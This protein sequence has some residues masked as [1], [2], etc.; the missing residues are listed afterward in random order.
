MI[1]LCLNLA[2]A[3]TVCISP[4]VPT[5]ASRLYP[6]LG[7]TG[8]PQRFSEAEAFDLSSDASSPAL[9]VQVGERILERIHP[10]NVQAIIDASKVAPVNAQAPKKSAQKA[11]PSPEA[12]IIKIDDLLKVALRIGHIQ[13]AEEVEGSSKLLKLKVDLAESSPRTIFAGIKE[14]YRPEQLRGK[15][16][17]VVANLK[18]RKMRFGT[19]EGMVLAGGPGGEKLWLPFFPDDAQ[20]GAEI[21]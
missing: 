20:I 10:K 11:T 3:A 5:L 9:S 13:E 8:R 4:A 19:S 16:V 21:R 6:C 12:G 18:P 17:A 1:T 2:R 15:K 7:L 14:A